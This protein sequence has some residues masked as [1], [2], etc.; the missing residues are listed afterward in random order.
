MRSTFVLAALAVALVIASAAQ[1]QDKTLT[2]GHPVRLG[3]AFPIA[4]GE[5]AVLGAASVTIPRRGS[6]LGLFPVEV[7]YGIFPRTQLTVGSTLS[8]HPHE[9]D[10][11]RAGDLDV[12][13]RMNLGA[14]TRF[15]PSMAGLLGV[16]FPTGVDS[17]A[18][19]VIAK[20][21][22]TK[23]I[24]Q[25]VDVHLN[26]EEDLSDRADSDERQ[27]RYRL[28]LGASAVI[29]TY[30]ALML[31]GDVFADQAKR[32]GTPTTVGLEMGLRYRLSPTIYWDAGVGTDVAGPA[33]RR[34]FFFTTGLSVGFKVGR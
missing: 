13:V 10:D 19:V 25:Q 28:A 33:D 27:A 9:A 17:T 5:G 22:A 12:N 18:Y 11:P 34:R 30:A 1:G 29:P 6:A 23:T 14:E 7:Q 21:Y 26:V 32:I 16:T 20:A 2:E 8:S 24:A 15:L 4:T 31:V 3:D